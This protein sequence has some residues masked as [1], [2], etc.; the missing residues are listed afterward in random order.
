MVTHINGA[1]Y[2]LPT[3][4]L[5]INISFCLYSPLSKFTSDDLREP[6]HIKAL[7]DIKGVMTQFSRFLQQEFEAMTHSLRDTSFDMSFRNWVKTFKNASA[8]GI[9]TPDGEENELKRLQGLQR[10]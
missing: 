9:L 5:T 4:I 7:T 6:K 3:I 10:L 8:L 2:I 1:S